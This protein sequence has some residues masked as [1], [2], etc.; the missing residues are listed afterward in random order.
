MFDR[1]NFG[2][3]DVG[4]DRRTRELGSW[5]QPAKHIGDDWKLD[6]PSKEGIDK[7]I[8][9]IRM[10]KVTEEDE[11]STGQINEFKKALNKM[12][13]SRETGVDCFLKH[14]DSDY[15]GNDIAT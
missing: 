10:G 2:V 13:H 3:R 1:F 7:L 11:L 6:N 14:Q 5:Y 12:Y 4:I 9:D 8:R 15:N